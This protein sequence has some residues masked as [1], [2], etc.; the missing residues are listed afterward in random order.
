MNVMIGSDSYTTFQRGNSRD[1]GTSSTIWQSLCQTCSTWLDY[2]AGSKTIRKPK[3]AQA[4][5]N[6]KPPVYETSSFRPQLSIRLKKASCA[7]SSTG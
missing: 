5:C 7:T 1:L 6:K 4:N 2:S 3:I